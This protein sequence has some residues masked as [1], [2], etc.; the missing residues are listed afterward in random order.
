MEKAFIRVGGALAAAFSVRALAGLALMVDDMQVLGRRI[1]LISD[2]SVQASNNLNRLTQIATRAGQRIGDVTM[3]FEGFKRIQ[4]DIKATNTELLDFTEALTQLAVIGG[5]GPQQTADALR[6]LNQGLAGGTLRAE[7]FNS[8]IENTPEIAK[9][10]GTGFGVSL[11]G[12]REMVLAGEVFSRD[13]LNA[14]LEQTDDIAARFEEIPKSMQQLFQSAKNELAIYVTRLSESLGITEAINDALEAVIS[15]LEAAN[16]ANQQLGETT[17]NEA[18]RRE[19]SQLAIIIGLDDEIVRQKE[20]IEFFKEQGALAGDLAREEE[21]LEKLTLDRI[22]ALKEL[23]S[24]ML[25]VVELVNEENK[26]TAEV[27]ENIEKAALMAE[28]KAFANARNLELERA[29]NQESRL[30]VGGTRLV[31]DPT[32]GSGRGRFAGAGGPDDPLEPDVTRQQLPF[33]D[34]LIQLG[35]RNA[36]IEEEA[37]R[38][39]QALSDL[40][41]IG[42]D[43]RAMLQARIDEKIAADRMAFQAQQLSVFGGFLSQANNLIVAAG[44]EGTAAQKAVAI[45]QAAI[46]AQQIIAA[47]EVAAAKA[48]AFAAGAGPIAALTSARALRTTSRISAGIVLGLSFG[49]GRQTG[50]PVGG[51]QLTPVNEN[52]DP[53]LFVQGGRQFLLPGGKG[54]KVVSGRELEAGGTGSASV[55]IINAGPPLQ[56]TGTQ[57]DGPNMK[58]FVKQAVD[59]AVAKINRSIS[60]N[61]GP[62]AQALESA[63][64]T[65]RR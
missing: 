36:Q 44:G 59:T 54:G 40:T 3:V 55:T 31:N 20:V 26:E 23:D 28:R 58:V 4:D 15:R 35:D 47:G 18:R 42:A 6:Q 11:G 10:I 61:Q 30:A 57:Q 51:N 48:A 12:L 16:K 21:R 24:I 46:Q 32:R 38:H 34:L 41:Q 65:R 62:T 33:S 7:E 5:A 29:A 22:F 43:D 60:S 52:G 25:R 17:E 14:I 8:I 27:A 50:G 13:V 49:A 19:K 37:R 9:A 56:V 63:G 45:A 1:E 2:N 39:E 53:E 64:F